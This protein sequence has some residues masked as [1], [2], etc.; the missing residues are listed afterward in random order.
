MQGVSRTRII[1]VRQIRDRTGLSPF[2]VASRNLTLERSATS[3]SLAANAE[4]ARVVLTSRSILHDILERGP[5]PSALKPETFPFLASLARERV[6]FRAYRSSRFRLS[7]SS[8]RFFLSVGKRARYIRDTLCERN[9]RTISRCRWLVAR[10]DR[11]WS[12]R[13]NERTVEGRHMWE[14]RGD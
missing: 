13:W 5:C 3:A 10:R 6:Y 14:G 11:R 4:S 1:L 7:I 9:E 12:R 8:A 2:P